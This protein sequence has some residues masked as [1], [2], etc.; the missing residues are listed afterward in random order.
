MC[1]ISFN[2]IIKTLIDNTTDETEADTWFNIPKSIL[3]EGAPGI[4]KTI[5]LKEI[6]CRWTNGTIF[7]NVR[8][9]F[10][11]FLRDSRFHSVT[12]INEL[13]YRTKLWQ[14]WQIA[15]IRQVFFC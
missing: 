2:H 13:P 6:A 8:I 9:V 5:L 10:L 1:C 3:I 12:T 11:I 14:I 15:T 7:D 4:G